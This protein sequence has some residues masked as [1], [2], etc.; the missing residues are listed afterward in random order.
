MSKEKVII[1]ADGACSGNPGK[2]GWCSILKHGNQEKILKGSEGFTTNNR[3]ELSAVIEGL[4]ALKRPVDVVVITD[5]EYVVNGFTKGWIKKWTK[6]GWKSNNGPV[7]NKELWMRL[8]SLVDKQE[9]VEF[10]WTRGHDDNEINNRCD[11]IAQ[12][13]AGSNTGKSRI[14]FIC[15]SH[16]DIL[17]IIEGLS[18]EEIKHKPKCPVCGKDMSVQQT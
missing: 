17:V 2:G 7:K 3:M 11:E 5:S 10:Q 4:N 18:T 8:K 6:N 14:G 16:N 1:Y 13:L 15:M 9:S 12:R